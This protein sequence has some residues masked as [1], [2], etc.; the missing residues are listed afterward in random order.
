MGCGTVANSKWFLGPTQIYEVLQG[1]VHGGHSVTLPLL[2]FNGGKTSTELL[3]AEL[4]LLLKVG[5]SCFCLVCHCFPAIFLG[6]P[7]TGGSVH[8]I[9]SLK[10]NR[11]RRYHFIKG[12]KNVISSRRQLYGERPNTFCHQC[13]HCTS[14]WGSEIFPMALVKWGWLCFKVLAKVIPLVMIIILLILIINDNSEIHTNTVHCI[15][16]TKSLYKKEDINIINPRN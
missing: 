1:Q 2:W 12:T 9:P 15:L 6:W 16:Q 10:H 8:W 13:P 14:Y 7:I 4:Q 11:R 5:G 3:R